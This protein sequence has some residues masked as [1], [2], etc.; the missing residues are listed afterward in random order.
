VRTRSSGRLAVRPTGRGIAVFLLGALLLAAGVVW[1]YPGLVAFGAGLVGLAV[2]G[3]VSVL[4]AG[5][6]AVDRTVAPLSV[7]RQDACSGVLR[8]GVRGVPFGTRFAAVERVAGE[9]VPV[10]LPAPTAGLTE[11]RYDI[12]TGRRGVVTVGPLVLRRTDFA[13]LAAGRAVLPGEIEVR[14]LPRV[15][16]VTGVPAG[17]RRGHDSGGGRIELSGTDLRGLRE[18]APG[19]D[20]RR[21]H[22]PTSARMGRPMVREDADPARAQLLV[23]LDDRADS[24]LTGDFEDAV[25]V[26]ASLVNAAAGA[27]QPVRLA[28]AS[29]RLD[30]ADPTRALAALAEVAMAGAVPAVPPAAGQDVL[31]VVTGD[32]GAGPG[33]LFAAAGEA[34]TGVLLVVDTSPD[35]MVAA[36]GPALILRGPRAEDLLHAWDLYVGVPA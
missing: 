27:S 24:Y 16:P 17:S 35:R 1:R 18:Y 11:V 13:G 29:G 36:T 15:L 4:L 5:P 8:L 12:P 10:L 6:V 31:V 26:A 32:R 23:V 9:A 28:T 25:E 30:L 14:V 22:G 20:L 34:A 19:D 2:A 21:L 7:P 3:V 33:G